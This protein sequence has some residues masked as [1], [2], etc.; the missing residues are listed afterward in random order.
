M[1][2]FTILFT[3]SGGGLSAELRRRVLLSTKYNIKIVAVD[4]VESQ[5]AK[6]FCNYFSIVPLGNNEKYLEI[7]EELVIK[8]KV[9]MVIPCSDEEALALSKNRN[10]IERHDCV[11]TCTNY[12]TLKIL[13]NKIQTYRFLK[14]KGIETPEF[15]EVNTL[16][17]LENKV[18]YF[19]NKNID[20]VV[21]P[22]SGRGGRNVSIISRTD[23]SKCLTEKEF[24][25]NKIQQYKNLFPVIVMERFIEPI[26]DVDM[27]SFNGVLK[28]SVVRRRINP[29][30]PNEGHIIENIQSLHNLAKNISKIF[31]LSWLYDCDV[32]MSKRG[33]PMI[34]EINPRP[35]GSIAITVAAGFNF[36]DDMIALYNKEDLNS[37]NINNNQIIIPYIS[38]V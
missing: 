26:F 14:E 21:K 28:S 25:K 23:L 20:V 35:S 33:I 34:L 22:S 29:N 12:E 32:M 36:I 38:L 3:C 17:Q 1:K 18:S 30:E 7:I 11:L 31:N 16:S 2:P 8:Y 27:L 13:S 4:N 19:L 5:S 10:K 24:T 37:Y 15:Y 9:N 6:I